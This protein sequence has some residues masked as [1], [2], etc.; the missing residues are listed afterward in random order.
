MT[1][2]RGGRSLLIGFALLAT[3]I[4]LVEI[5]SA[6]RSN[7]TPRP[8][9]ATSRSQTGDSQSLGRIDRSGGGTA[10]AS[11]GR[12]FVSLSCVSGNL[13]LR[14]NLEVVH[15]SMDCARVVPQSI[16]DRF[17][18]QPVAVT[19]AGRAITIDSPTAG[20]IVLSEVK[21]FSVSS[22]DATP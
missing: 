15:A 18:S 9:S 8:T 4:T 10:V 7:A 3:V 13:T 14:T 19:Y 20:T 1:S 2:F 11:D 22:A 16:I 21:D 17:V 6:C 12:L 5:L